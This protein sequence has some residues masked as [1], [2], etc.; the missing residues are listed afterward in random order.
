MLIST[1]SSTD[2][3]LKK[4]PCIS[5]GMNIMLISTDYN[6]F[7]KLTDWCDQTDKCFSKR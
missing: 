3:F 4:N 2:F 6:L 1:K 7:S 5:F